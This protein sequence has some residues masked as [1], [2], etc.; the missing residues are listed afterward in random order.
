MKTTFVFLIF[1]TVPRKEVI[2]TFMNIHQ[3]VL[4]DYIAAADSTSNC[5]FGL[6]LGTAGSYGVEQL[7]V[8]PST[9][10]EDLAVTAIFQPCGVK[11]SVPAAG[12]VIDVPWEATADELPYPKGRILFQGYAEGKLVNSCDIIYT[13]SGHSAT[14]GAEGQ[15]PPTPQPGGSDGGYY[16]PTVQ[17]GVLSW[18]PSKAD[19]PPAESANVQGPAGAPGADGITPT[20]G[21]NGNWYLGEIDTGKPSRGEQGPAG[22]D[23]APGPA[24]QDGTQGPQGEPGQPGEPGKDGENGGYYTPSVDTAGNLSWTPSKVNMPP[25]P[26][27]NIRGPQGEPGQPGEKGDPYTLTEE[28]LTTIVQAVLAALPNGDEVSY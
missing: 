4:T 26:G 8:I 1:E 21:A 6:Y 11:V 28:D 27:A 7:E 12:G 13:V 23:G 15:P 5:I 24:G 2:K 9:G 16:F 3:I 14:D 18:Q 19:M 10:W 22:Q 20:I 25:V 17:D